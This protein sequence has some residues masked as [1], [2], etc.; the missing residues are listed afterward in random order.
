MCTKEIITI[1]LRKR[2]PELKATW[3]PSTKPK[4]RLE[5]NWSGCENNPKPEQQNQRAGKTTIMR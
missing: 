5:K 1:M 3:L 2:L 4:T